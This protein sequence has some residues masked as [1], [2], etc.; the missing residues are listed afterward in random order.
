MLSFAYEIMT[1]KQLKNIDIST[2][3]GTLNKFSKM[4]KSFL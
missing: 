4:R 3:I 2:K 1:K